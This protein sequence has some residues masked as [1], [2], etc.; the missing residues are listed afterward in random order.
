MAGPSFLYDVGDVDGR[1]VNAPVWLRWLVLA[2]PLACGGEPTP[3]GSNPT[4][5]EGE[6]AAAPI[7]VSTDAGVKK[8]W[9]RFKGEVLGDKDCIARPK[10]FPTAVVVG[11]FAH[12]RGCRLK[13]VFIGEQLHSSSRGQRARYAHETLKSAGFVDAPEARKHELARAYVD[14][15]IHAFRDGLVTKATP[16]FALEE[17]PEYAAP[18]V[19]TVTDETHVAGWVPLP[20][21]DKDETGY[22]H[23]EWRFSSAGFLR[24]SLS[25]RFTVTGARLR[26]EEGPPPKPALADAPPTPSPS[27]S[28]SPDPLPGDAGA[29]GNAPPDPSAP[30][31]PAPKKGP[32]PP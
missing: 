15:V 18:T 20:A 13:G 12:D 11:L 25:N 9:E 14:E 10:A 4:K 22:I 21:G 24:T 31:E 17:T 19:K 26:G 7:D 29:E 3:G 27:D 5:R 2:A 30:A 23:G 8:A 16:A 32:A 28:A 1:R 6:V